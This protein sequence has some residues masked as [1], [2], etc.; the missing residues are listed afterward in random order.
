MAGLEGPPAS[1]LAMSKDGASLL[2]AGEDELESTT[3][4][5]ID[6]L[7]SNYIGEFGSRQI[8]LFSIVSFAWL[9]AAFATL[10]MAFFGTFGNFPVPFKLH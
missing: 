3:P 8:C 2:A 6:E 9:P 7:F 1:R 5:T 4:V 10:N